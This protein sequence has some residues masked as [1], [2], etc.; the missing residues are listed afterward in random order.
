[1]CKWLFRRSGE[2]QFKTWMNTTALENVSS[3]LKAFQVQFDV[4][5]TC[6]NGW[7]C[8]IFHLIHCD[9]FKMLGEADDRSEK[10]ER[11]YIFRN[12]HRI[13]KET[14]DDCSSTQHFIF[15]YKI[16]GLR[17]SFFLIKKKICTFTWILPFFRWK[18]TAQS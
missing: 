14:I 5:I 12:W 17:T 7:I 16:Y 8:Y 6:H 9:K 13:A 1:M 11:C 10:G 15:K 3:N 4:I 18:N 2:K